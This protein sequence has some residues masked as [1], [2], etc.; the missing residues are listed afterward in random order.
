MFFVFEQNTYNRISPIKEFPIS[1]KS[2]E[3]LGSEI[4]LHTTPIMEP[5]P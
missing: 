1:A 3:K 2:T 4:L 5:N